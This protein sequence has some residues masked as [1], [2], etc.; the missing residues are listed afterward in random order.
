GVKLMDM[1]GIE[2][3]DDPELYA[4]MIEAYINLK[5]KVDA[6]KYIDKAILKFPD[7]VRRFNIYSSKVI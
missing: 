5:K 7:K 3:F 2:K 6:K 1:V 4:A